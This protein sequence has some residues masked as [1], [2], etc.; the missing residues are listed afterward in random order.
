MIDP[1]IIVAI[2]TYDCDDALTLL[3]QLNPELCKVKVGSIVFNALG[4]DFLKLVDNFS[5]GCSKNY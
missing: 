2:D 5:Y 3:D 1:K 4:K